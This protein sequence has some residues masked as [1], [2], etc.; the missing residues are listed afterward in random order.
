MSL[1][2]LAAAASVTLPP[3]L[4]LPNSPALGGAD[5]GIRLPNERRA[6]YDAALCLDR[7]LNAIGSPT[8]RVHP[9]AVP[10]PPVP[11]RRTMTL[12]ATRRAAEMHMSVVRELLERKHP[13]TARTPL[14]RDGL[15]DGHCF[16]PRF[17]VSVYL[18][19]SP[20]GGRQ[21]SVP[22]TS[23]KPRSGWFFC[24]EPAL[25]GAA[26]GRTSFDPRWRPHRALKC[27]E[28]LSRLARV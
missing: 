20:D 18:A 22:P 8:L 5:D 9:F 1:R 21:A 26:P 10:L 3:L 15:K 14:L 27:G 13:G 11:R 24:W 28:Q 25:S 2:L 17:R 4:E 12:P 6:A 16:A 19:E 23:R 7:K